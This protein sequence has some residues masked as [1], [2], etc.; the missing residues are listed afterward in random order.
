MIIH[1]C[2]CFNMFQPAKSNNATM[3][4]MLRTWKKQQR[5]CRRCWRCRSSH[6]KYNLTNGGTVRHRDKNS[7]YNPAGGFKSFHFWEYQT[8]WVTCLGWLQ[9]TGSSWKPVSAVDLQLVPDRDLLCNSEE[10]PDCVILFTLRGMCHSYPQLLGFTSLRF[11]QT[12]S[13]RLFWDTYSK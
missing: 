4:Q 9:V 6:V 5:H 8:N 2:T 3:V 1:A 7:S 13:K 10:G 11:I 12:H